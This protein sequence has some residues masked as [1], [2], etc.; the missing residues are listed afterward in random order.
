MILPQAPVPTAPP[1]PRPGPLSMV[2]R[3]ALGLV[4]LAVPVFAWWLAT[5]LGAH[6]GMPVLVALG[7]GLALVIGLPIVWDLWAEARWRRK[8]PPPARILSRADRIRL[9]IFTVAFV[10]SAGA[11][12]A[13]SR[14]SVNALAA[15][16]D[17]VLAGAEGG[18]AT[19]VRKAIGG[20]AAGLGSALGVSPDVAGSS[21]ALAPPTA[22]PPAVPGTTAPSDS[23]TLARPATPTAPP[24]PDPGRGSEVVRVAWPLPA[25][26]HPAIR[27]LTD[28][29]ATSIDA[30]AAYIKAREGDPLQRV[31]AIHDF[32]VRHLTYDTS[33][34]KRDAVTP[35]QAAADVFASRKATCDGFSNLMVALGERTGDP[36]VK[37]VGRSRGTGSQPSGFYHAWVAADVAG[38]WR[39]I[40]PTWDA[41]AVFGDEFRARYA[42]SYLFTPPSVF[43]NDHLP[44]EPRWSL[45]DPPLTMEAFVA[46][47]A[48]T[49]HFVALGLELR[50]VAS[51]SVE[52]N[53][54]VSFAI[55]NPRGVWVHVL[56]IP[57]TAEAKPFACTVPTD[58]NP[59]EVVCMFTAPGVW[60]LEL[61]ANDAPSGAFQSIGFIQATNRP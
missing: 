25:E 31:K 43:A 34:L 11:L 2:F 44:D 55:G 39:F 6:A 19:G 48:M 40:D 7:L 4:A 3:L 30:V 18:F 45:L 20:I 53:G 26:P 5:S 35:S 17:W 57:K 41:G 58:A 10:F 59:V 36:M 51:S 50:G 38:A 42:T 32:V 27:T 24:P 28:S 47:P 21:V 23:G 46:R 29:Q 8:Q 61:Y 16:G 56:A 1:P 9:R 12:L 49:A 22:V 15:R 14:P 33:V 60:E 52:V 13:A 54:Q 37:I